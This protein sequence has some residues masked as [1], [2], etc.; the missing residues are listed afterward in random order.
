MSYF[1]EFYIDEAIENFN[2]Y[3]EFI[4]TN[5]LNDY[6]S[7]VEEKICEESDFIV[8]HLPFDVEI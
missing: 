3:D 5:F 8:R 2:S 7:E 6:F 1:D 4:V